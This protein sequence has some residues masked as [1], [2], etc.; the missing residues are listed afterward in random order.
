LR[1]QNQISMIT[2]DEKDKEYESTGGYELG[3]DK[4]PGRE[5]V[6]GE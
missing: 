3:A 2:L 1:Y 6:G 4:I 5:W